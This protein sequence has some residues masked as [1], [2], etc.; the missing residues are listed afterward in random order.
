LD[1]EINILEPVTG[2][3]SDTFKVTAVVFPGDIVVFNSDFASD[4]ETGPPPSLPT[5]NVITETGDWQLLVTATSGNDD[6]ISFEFR[7][8]VPEP[9]TLILLEF[10]LLGLAAWGRRKTA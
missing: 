6:L 9:S 7:S 3:V 2:L 5:T 8:D 1:F 10:G 4:T